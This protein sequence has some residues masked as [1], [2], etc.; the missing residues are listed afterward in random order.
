VKPPEHL[1]DLLPEPFEEPDR[2]HPSEESREL[3]NWLAALPRFDAAIRVDR[4]TINELRAFGDHAWDVHEYQ[5]GIEY[6]QHHDNQWPNVVV[7]P[8]RIP[9][10]PKECT[11]AYPKRADYWLAWCIEI[12]VRRVLGRSYGG[13][14]S[15]NRSGDG[16][17]RS[18]IFRKVID[19]YDPGRTGAAGSAVGLGD[20]RNPSYR[21]D[22]PKREV[23]VSAYRRADRGPAK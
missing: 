22:L 8:E 1:C 2:D 16:G 13:A 7:Q 20:P 3:G 10:P 23:F 9:L 5:W 4:V 15:N 17:L 14:W 21:R 6:L 11:G 12:L 19:V 18:R